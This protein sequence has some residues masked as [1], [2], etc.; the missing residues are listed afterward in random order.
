MTTLRIL[1]SI[2]TNLDN[3]GSFSSPKNLYRSAKKRIPKLKYQDVVDFLQ[4]QD[5]Y[6]LHRAA[7]SKFKRRKTISRGILHQIQVD[8]IDV[9]KYKQYNPNT[10]FL[11]TCICVFSRKVWVEPLANKSGKVVAKAFMKIFKRMSKRV[12][13][14]QSDNGVEFYNKHVRALFDSKGIKHFSTS[15]DTKSAVCER[16]NR[17]LLSKI[18]K[19]FTKKKTW[20]YLNV[21]QRI[22]DTYNSTPHRSL[23]YLS[24]TEITPRNEKAVWDFQYKDYFSKNKTRF[25][26]KIDDL[27][28]ISKYAKT[29][30]KGYLQT[31]SSEVF[32]VHHR[33][34]TN[35]PT[36]KL[37]SLDGE[38]IT[39]IFYPAELTKV[40][41][42][43]G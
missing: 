35:P 22:V 36:Y 5:S 11:L 18:H 32:R 4:T 25:K 6:T 43:L 7:R 9:S 23:N 42:I 14:V 41:T 1:H 37:K 19:Y 34:A 26:F 39:G 20:H 17:T 3:P 2:Y 16:F 8:L 38:E 31:M 21:L 28:R 40:S 33:S 13:L 24:P 12:S 27:V 30:R 29:F 15:S 10:T